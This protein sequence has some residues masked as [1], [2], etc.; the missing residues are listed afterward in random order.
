[1]SETGKLD[2]LVPLALGAFALDATDYTAAKAAL[3]TWVKK[4]PIDALA[5]TVIGGGLAFYAA[6]RESNPNVQHPWD[7]ILY[8]ATCLSVGYD[9][10]F[11]TT[12]VGH[13]IASFVQTFGPQ[14][15]NTALDAPASE[16]AAA[17]AEN[18]AVQRAILARLDDIV[19][20]LQETA[21]S[22]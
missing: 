10:C 16:V 19:R 2:Q 1:V 5:V 7:A 11:P 21:A 3:R 14:M 17:E 18:A 22:R 8:V 9:N 13:A 15:A 4:D 20:L 12:T 6:E